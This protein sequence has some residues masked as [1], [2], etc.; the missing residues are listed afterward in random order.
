MQHDIA[1]KLQ[2]ARKAS[3]RGILRLCRVSCFG[4]SQGRIL[5][6][7]ACVLTCVL[8]SSMFAAS[9]QALIS[10]SL[11]QGF[12]QNVCPS[13]ETNSVALVKTLLGRSCLARRQ[14]KLGDVRFRVQGRWFCSLRQRGLLPPRPCAFRPG[15]FALQF[16]SS[17]T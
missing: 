5:R 16:V 4:M 11:V 12:G 14:C 6:P 10:G 2:H 8:L 7:N 1:A 9:S 17:K 15:A 3:A 13:H